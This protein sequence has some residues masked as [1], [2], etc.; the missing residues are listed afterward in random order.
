[1]R[2]IAAV[3]LAVCLMSA[4]SENVCHRRFITVQRLC[5]G[6]VCVMTLASVI[7]SAVSGVQIR[8]PNILEEEIDTEGYEKAVKESFERGIE[9]YIM[10][11]SGISD[12][13]IRVITDGLDT[14]SMRA[15]YIALHFYGRAVTSDYIQIREKISE[16]FL[17]EGGRCVVNIEGE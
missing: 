9:K 11:E 3:C 8:L 16:N 12:D 4:L 17:A 1:M 7:F 10:Q 2:E 15:K 13:E 14:A 5:V 6:A